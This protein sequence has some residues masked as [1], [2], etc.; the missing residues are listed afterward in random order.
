MK[1]RV[2]RKVP[3]QKKKETKLQ[4]NLS[5]C[6][7]E[8]ANF[9]E[10]DISEKDNESSIKVYSSPNESS[11]PKELK[12]SMRKSTFSTYPPSPETNSRKKEY[13]EKIKE[14]MREVRTST[15]AMSN[16]SYTK[17]G[18]GKAPPIPK[19]SSHVISQNK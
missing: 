3:H 7:D 6:V 8:T 12:S 10:S 13:I 18:F 4:L 19:F 17:I 9:A 2:S 15:L 5:P 16:S 1:V 11:R 14:A